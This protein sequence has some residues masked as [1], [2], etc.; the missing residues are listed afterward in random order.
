M[1][2]AIPLLIPDLH[3]ALDRDMGVVDKD[4][5]EKDQNEKDMLINL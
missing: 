1:L 5:M 3:R 2:G 4:R